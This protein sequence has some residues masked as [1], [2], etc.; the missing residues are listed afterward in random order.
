MA[1][2]DGIFAAAGVNERIR[3]PG[4]DVQIIRRRVDILID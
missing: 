3:H 4:G 1:H 2:V